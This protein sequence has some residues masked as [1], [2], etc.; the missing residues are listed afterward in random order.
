M[1][2][3]VF[4]NTVFRNIFNINSAKE[5]EYVILYRGG[6]EGVESFIQ[7]HSLVFFLIFIFSVTIVSNEVSNTFTT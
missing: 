1:F 2:S 4:R 5:P 7:T 3:Y 6:G